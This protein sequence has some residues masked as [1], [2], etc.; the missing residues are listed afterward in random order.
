MYKWTIC[1]TTYIGILWKP[2]MQE[3]RIIVINISEKYVRIVSTWL[4]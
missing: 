1:V 3:K 2:M 4:K